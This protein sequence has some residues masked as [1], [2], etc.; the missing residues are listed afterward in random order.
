[1]GGG[2]SRGEVKRTQETD[3]Q[4]SAS[5]N[6]SVSCGTQVVVMGRHEQ[7]GGGGLQ[8]CCRRGVGGDFVGGAEGGVGPD[9]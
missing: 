5:L 7:E 2:P 4:E 6:L 1:M 9:K 8:Q 3:G